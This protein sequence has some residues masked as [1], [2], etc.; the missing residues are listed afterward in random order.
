MKILQRFFP[1]ELYIPETHRS[2]AVE[3]TILLIVWTEHIIFLIFTEFSERYSFNSGEYSW[4]PSVHHRP[5]QFNTRTTPFQPQKLPVED[6]KYVSSTH[7]SVQHQKIVRSTQN[8]VQHKNSNIRIIYHWEWLIRYGSP[9]TSAI[10]VLKRAIFVVFCVELTAVL[11]WRFFVSNWRFF[12]IELAS[13][14]NWPFL[15]VE[16][17]HLCWTDAFLWWI[18]GFWGL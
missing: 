17:T 5:P 1:L 18:D 9:V 13:V 14:L 2:R 16:L 6:V 7:L 8:T 15:C 11:N 10:V 4:G 12:G 3:K